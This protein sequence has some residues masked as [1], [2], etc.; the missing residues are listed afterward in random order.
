[1]E[2]ARR[3]FWGSAVT[4]T[5]RL[6][7]HVSYTQR[8]NSPFQGLAADGNKLALFRLLRNGL[9]VCGFVHDEML[10]LVPDGTDYDA[11]VARV[12]EIMRECMEELTAGVPI[13]T[14]YLLG[15]RWYK[16]ID[17]QPRD[18]AGHILP[19]TRK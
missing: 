19:F 13:T 6:R 2:L 1:L 18:E 8:A 7:G 3:I 5:G 17:E 10:I 11:V 16:G 9:R 12:Q 15:D 4:L 14:E